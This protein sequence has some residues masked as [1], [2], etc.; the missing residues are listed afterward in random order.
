VQEGAAAVGCVERRGS[1]RQGPY[2]TSIIQSSNML[3]TS[4]A[5][6]AMTPSSLNEWIRLVV[7]PTVGIC[8]AIYLSVVNGWQ[9]YE[10]PLIVLLVFGPSVVQGVNKNGGKKN[11][12]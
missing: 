1:E 5:G 7:G 8:L 9:A 11:G 4:S 10:P 3:V 12:T 2:I 6:A